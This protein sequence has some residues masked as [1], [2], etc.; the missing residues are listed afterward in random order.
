MFELGAVNVKFLVEERGTGTGTCP[1]TSLSPVSVITSELHTC[2]NLEAKL[3]GK[4][5]G[6]SLIN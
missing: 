5:S 3:V 4:T 1:C 6:R 2:V